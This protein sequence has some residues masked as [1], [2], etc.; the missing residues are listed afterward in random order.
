M[1]EE[2]PRATILVGFLLVL[3]GGVIFPLLLV[4]KVVPSTF[5]GDILSYVLSVTGF[6]LGVIG[7]VFYVRL[8]RKKAN[9]GDDPDPLKMI[10]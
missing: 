5:F 3:G 6:F 2:H 10:K 9:P 8:N 4:I 7:S 1:I